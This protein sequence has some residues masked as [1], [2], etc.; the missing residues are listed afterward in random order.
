LLDVTRKKNREVAI[1]SENSS[2]FLHWKQGVQSGTNAFELI[3][4]AVIYLAF[5]DFSRSNWCHEWRNG[6]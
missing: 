2:L 1:Y 5:D 4:Q 3:N 6:C